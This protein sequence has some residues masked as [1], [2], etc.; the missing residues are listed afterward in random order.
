MVRLDFVSNSS[1]SSFMIIGTYIDRDELKDILF[2]T[3][4]IN[5]ADMSE[6]EIDD[7]F[8]QILYDC[9]LDWHHGLEEY[10]DTVICIGLSYDSMNK[11]ET[12][13]EFEDRIKNTLNRFMG[14]TG[15][16]HSMLDCG[17]D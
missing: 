6:Q 3:K 11:D 1:S 4:G 14:Y 9:P 2:K 5:T 7:M 12:K 13:F 10:G 8:Y 17:Y 15:P 16:I